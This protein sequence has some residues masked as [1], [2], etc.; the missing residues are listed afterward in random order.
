MSPSTILGSMRISPYKMKGFL[1]SYD[2]C[3]RMLVVFWC[4]IVIIHTLSGACIEGTK[5]SIILEKL[6]LLFNKVA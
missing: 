1:N 6:N 2:L 5:A 3:V 4:C